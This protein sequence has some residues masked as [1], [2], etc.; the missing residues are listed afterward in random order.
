VPAGNYLLKTTF[1]GYPLSVPVTVK[2]GAT[3]FVLF[4]Q[5]QPPKIQP[6]LTP[7]PAVQPPATEQPPN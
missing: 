7:V 6:T 3:S 4:Q 2:S 5:T 1:D